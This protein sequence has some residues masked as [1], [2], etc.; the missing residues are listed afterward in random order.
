MGVWE[1]VLIALIALVVAG[2]ER[3]PTIM[4]T[5]GYWVGRGKATLHGLQSELE[6]ETNSLGRDLDPSEGPEKT[7]PNKHEDGR[8]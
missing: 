4:R 3:L 1:I 5:L 7:T 6:R 2:P 8:D